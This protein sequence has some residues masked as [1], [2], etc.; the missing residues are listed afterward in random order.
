MHPIH[1]L[2]T[3]Y[4]PPVHPLYTPHTPYTT[5][6]QP[7]YTPYTPLMHPLYTPYTTPTHP[8]CTPTR[9]HLHLAPRAFRHLAELQHVRLE[10]FG[11]EVLQEPSRVVGGTPHPVMHVVTKGRLEEY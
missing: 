2:Y 1:P 7:P 9:T 4:T 3:P 10:L 6:I 8:S 11:D 5:P